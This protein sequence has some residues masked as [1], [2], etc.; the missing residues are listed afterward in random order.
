MSRKVALSFTVKI[1]IG[2]EIKYTNIKNR[3]TEYDAECSWIDVLD[4]IS[5]FLGPDEVLLPSDQLSVTVSVMSNYQP[6]D[7]T[8][9]VVLNDPI[10]IIQKFDPNLKHVTISLKRDVHD[11]RDSPP[12]P[13]QNTQSPT[14]SGLGI[15]KK[16]Q[17]VR[18]VVNC[19]NCT[20]PRC[21]FAQKKL[22]LEEE[23]SLDKLLKTTEYCCGDPLTGTGNLEG[24]RVDSSLNC[25]THIEY[26]YYASKKAIPDLCCICC[27]RHARKSPKLLRDFEFVLPACRICEVIEDI[28]KHSPW[29]K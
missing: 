17:Y 24:I 8:F 11:S 15:L 16:G 18:G 10:D 1:V 7:E 5:S 9:T 3:I 22:S 21:I 6:G 28:P 14:R 29:K 4:S 23:D 26:T 19:I 27:R 12:S 20:K 2:E 13:S 25:E